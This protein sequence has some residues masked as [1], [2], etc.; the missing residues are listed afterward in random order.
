MILLKIV[1]IYADGACRGNGKAENIGG[2]GI[3]LLFGEVKKELKKAVSNT[4]NNIMELSSVIDGLSILKEPCQVRV[5]SDSAYVVNAI[6]QKWIDAW[7]KNNWT[8]SSKD[9]VKNKELWVQLLNLLQIHK[10]EF[11]KVKGHSDN[12]WNNRCDELA[13]LAMDEFSN[14]K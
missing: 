8:T 2:Y 7:I 13:N 3:V 12:Q 1:E 4:T 9:P 14:N 5:Y 6:N 10:I 11:V